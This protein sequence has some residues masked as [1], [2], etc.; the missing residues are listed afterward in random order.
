MLFLHKQP[1]CSNL[2]LQ[3]RRITMETNFCTDYYYMVCQWI[4]QENEL[5]ITS[6]L[7]FNILINLYR[8]H[9]H[10]VPAHYWTS[11]FLPSALKHLCEKYTTSLQSHT[12]FLIFTS[13]PKQW[14]CIEQQQCHGVEVTGLGEYQRQT[15][16]CAT[17]FDALRRTKTT[18]FLICTDHQGC[19]IL[20]QGR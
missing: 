19:G 1:G 13:K 9:H 18:C 16:N 8:K 20:G 4:S 14:T 10:W 7:F 17:A 5:K 2:T 15:G 6:V 12:W 3:S 11:C